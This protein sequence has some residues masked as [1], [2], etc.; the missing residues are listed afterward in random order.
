MLKTK[1]INVESRNTK[2]I[3]VAKSTHL[4]DISSQHSPL[5]FSQNSRR[6][7]ALRRSNV[8]NIGT[9]H[10]PPAAF[11]FVFPLAFISYDIM[12]SQPSS[13]CQNLAN[14]YNSPSERKAPSPKHLRELISHGEEKVHNL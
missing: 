12:L 13:G 8:V 7:D 10:N 9:T 2:L 4:S 1:K 11:A 5:L 6:S 14:N 3:L